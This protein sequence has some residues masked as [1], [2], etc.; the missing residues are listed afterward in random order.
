M[1]NGDAGLGPVLAHNGTLVALGVEHL[2]VEQLGFVDV[3]GRMLQQ[4]VARAPERVG[5]RAV[6]AYLTHEFRS[7]NPGVEVDDVALECTR[8][9]LGGVNL[10]RGP[11]LGVSLK[12]NKDGDRRRVGDVIYD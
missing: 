7:R 6:G 5:A 8:V 1:A 11:V 12:A 2:R 4:T 9:K 10:Y 3:L